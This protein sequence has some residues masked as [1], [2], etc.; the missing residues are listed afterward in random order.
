MS[1]RSCAAIRQYPCCTSRCPFSQKNTVPPRRYL[2]NGNERP[3]RTIIGLVQGKDE[4]FC[5][6]KMALR[7]LPP[8]KK[9]CNKVS[10]LYPC[11]YT[12][13][14]ES[15]Y[16]TNNIRAVIS[17]S[18]QRCSHSARCCA[19]CVQMTSFIIGS[20]E[21]CFFKMYIYFFLSCQPRRRSENQQTMRTL[22]IKRSFVSSTA[23]FFFCRSADTVVRI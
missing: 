13:Y 16:A 15:E 21:I 8:S 3:N 20:E 4:A 2:R 7:L 22:I 10:I 9:Y 18:M 12:P 1:L 23:C 5:F 17:R 6:G 14:R 11:C 19:G